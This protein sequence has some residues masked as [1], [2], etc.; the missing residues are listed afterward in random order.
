M[1]ISQEIVP[2]MPQLRRFSRTLSGSQESGDAYVV[3][4]LEALVA[5]PSIFPDNLT[6][7]VGLYKLFLRM[8]NS[9]DDIHTV[10]NFDAG[11]SEAVHSVQTI[12]PLPRQT[13]LLLTV[14]G[15][16]PEEIAKIMDL[17]VGEIA[18]LIDQA[19]REIAEQ[20]PPS[21]IMIIEDEPLIA[22]NLQILV[23]GLGHRVTGIART[24]DEAIELVEK[25]PPQLILSDIQLDDGSSGVDAVNDILAMF[26]VPV[27]F[28]T[29]HPE[30]LLTGARP[31]PAFLIQ[32]PFDPKT[33]KAIVSQALF[34]DVKTHSPKALAAAAKD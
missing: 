32:K 12:T 14:E 21:V 8:W 25:D 29:G 26:E 4:V 18:T 9:L 15:F 2:L 31:E 30:L 13:F 19:D 11:E 20:L 34:F 24:R 6:P 10:L 7:R 17:E 16:K 27:I 33:V 5:D 3:A 28:V 1:S 23:E 22:A